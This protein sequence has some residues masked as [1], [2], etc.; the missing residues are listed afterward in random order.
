VGIGVLAQPQLVVRFMTVKSNKELNRGVLIGGIFIFVITG[1]AY[2]VGSLSNVFFFQQT[3]QIAVQVAQGNID[4]IIPIFI[5]SALPEWFTYLFMLT[6]ISAVM[7]TLSSQFHV[8][9]TSMGRD[10]YETIFNKKGEHSVTITRIGIVFAVLIALILAFILPGSIIAQGTALFFGICAAAFLSAYICAL[11]WK[12]ATKNGVIAGM[13]LGTLTSLFWLLFVYGKT[14]T[15]LG[16]LKALNG[17]SILISSQPWS[18]VDPLVIAV[19]VAMIITV[20]VSL[21]TEPPSKE[22][23]DKCFKGL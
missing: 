15:S 5:N 22:H 14:A 3:G 18:L 23:I 16:I 13:V 6:L 8:Q 20:L 10:I 21:I 12:R 2:M 7:S 19:P 11:F 1:S 17:Q 9:G 4:K